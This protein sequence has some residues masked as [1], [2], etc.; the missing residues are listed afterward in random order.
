VV[1]YAMGGEKCGKA[2]FGEG[3]RLRDVLDTYGVISGGEETTFMC[4]CVVQFE[5]RQ[6][7]VSHL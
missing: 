3:G 6:F 4:R 7:L 1:I 2:W 5:V